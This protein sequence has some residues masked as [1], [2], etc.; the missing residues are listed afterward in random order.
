MR[1]H[2]KEPISYQFGCRSIKEGLSEE[3]TFNV[4]SEEI[5]GMVQEMSIPFSRISK[6][7]LQS[8]FSELKDVKQDQS[9]WNDS[10]VVCNFVER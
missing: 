7:I 4:G 5:K 9:G 6:C 2:R 10:K 3:V 1:F 8:D